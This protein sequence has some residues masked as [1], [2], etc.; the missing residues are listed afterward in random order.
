MS[1]EVESIKAGLRQVD[2]YERK[3]LLRANEAKATRDALLRRLMRL[4]IPDMP[5]PRI[6]L[7]VRLGSAAAM[8]TL[9]GGATAYLLA[10]HAGL[11]RRSEE[12]L[13]AGRIAAAQGEASRGERAARL[14]AGLSIAPDA[15]GRFSYGA[16]PIDPAR[17]ASAAE[18]APLLSG[19]IDIAPGLASRMAPGD[20]LFV[21][22]RSRA[23]PDGVPLAAMRFDARRLPLDFDV[24][25]NAL[26]GAPD[27]LLRTP[28][29]IVTARVS[30][31]GSGSAAPGDLVG[32]SA[33][34][35]PWSRQ[36]RIVIDRALIGR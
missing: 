28:S 33:A 24:R 14:R 35:A 27:R 34:V 10:G 36:A 5:A 16:A 9:V 18:V 11:W 25:A 6:A 30:K 8:L 17:D 4:V 26:V 19:R 13:T 1:Q 21:I 32:T 12:L 20:A 22:V 31:T 15:D 7:Q 23:D 3:G 29:V 2:D